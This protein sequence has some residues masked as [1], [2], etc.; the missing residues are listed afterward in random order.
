MGSSPSCRLMSNTKKTIEALKEAGVR[1]RVKV[2][3]GGAPVQI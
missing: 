3:I 1:D 2:L